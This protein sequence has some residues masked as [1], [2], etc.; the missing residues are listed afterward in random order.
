MPVPSGR[1]DCLSQ[2]AASSQT[3]Q[4]TLQEL[5]PS[6]DAQIG[7]IE[8]QSINASPANT[9]NQQEHETLARERNERHII[10]STIDELQNV[11]PSKSTILLNRRSL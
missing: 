7:G 8:D 6:K 5:V 1:E 11:P 2:Q 10:P 9:A 4:A 3:A